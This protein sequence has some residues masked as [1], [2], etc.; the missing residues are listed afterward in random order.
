MADI[1]APDELKST[2]TPGAAAPSGAAPLRTPAPDVAAAERAAEEAF[3]ACEELLRE[4]EEIAVETQGT[5][6]D[7]RRN[8]AAVE[9]LE[10]LAPRM[11]LEAPERTAGAAARA[12][13]GISLEEWRRAVLADDG[14]DPPSG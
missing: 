9:A 8:R 3:A 5:Y 7:V 10:P 1:P 2:T 6:D 4:V 11:V 12:R 13:A 14:L